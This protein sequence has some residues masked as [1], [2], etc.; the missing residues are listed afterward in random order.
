LCGDDALEE[1]A[2]GLLGVLAAGADGTAERASQALMAGRSDGGGGLAA[3]LRA[4]AAPAA[5]CG[6]SNKLLMRSAVIALAYLDDPERMVSAVQAVC[7]LTHGETLARD[8]C[9]LWCT[10]IRHAVWHG[11]FDGLH[12]GLTLIP[13]ARKAQWSAWLADTESREPGCF[14]PNR[15]AAR[16]LQ[17]AWAAIVHTPVPA[18][19][20]ASGSFACQHLQRALAAAIR[21]GDDTE[22]IAGI[23]GALLGARWGASAIPLAWQRTM[24]A[25][26]GLGSRDLVRLGI[27][28]AQKGCDDDRGWPSADHVQRADVPR[29]RLIPH[30]FDPGVL[31]G[32]ITSAEGARVASDAVVSLCRLGRRDFATVAPDNHVQVWLIDLPGANAHLHFALDQAARAVADLRKEGKRVLLHCYAGRNRTVAVAVRYATLAC[33]VTPQEAMQAV[34]A[35]IDQ[36]GW[37]LNP[38][39]HAAVLEFSG[40]AVVGTSRVAPDPG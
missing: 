1:I 39:L 31:L 17:A 29:V 24:L 20:P 10:A 25:Y 32:N 3:A 37:P 21:I 7:Q 4:V 15:S 38:E 35:R 26:P 22:A 33:G 40:Q 12:A 18:Q 36:A 6:T 16:A 5:G 8:A 13:A 11:S 34:S 14:S 23:A 9:I 2:A 28:A 30:P 27:L 19:S